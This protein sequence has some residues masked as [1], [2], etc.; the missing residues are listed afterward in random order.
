MLY[1]WA[2]RSNC[3]Y[4]WKK[5][6]DFTWKYFVLTF[7]CCS[8]I[9]HRNVNACSWD[10]E[11][12]LKKGEILHFY[13]GTNILLKHFFPPTERLNWNTWIYHFFSNIQEGQRGTWRKWHVPSGQAILVK[14]TIWGWRKCG[15]RVLRQVPL[16]CKHR[17]SLA[18][19][20]AHCEMMWLQRSMRTKDQVANIGCVKPTDFEPLFNWWS[21]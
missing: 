19:Q 1:H 18:Q 6:V 11:E 17:G 13:Y 16:W 7:C 5:S 9:L 10:L 20:H 14:G 8:Y 21:L 3:M 12:L 2:A 15:C 4:R